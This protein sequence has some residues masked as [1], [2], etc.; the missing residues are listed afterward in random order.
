MFLLFKAFFQL[1]GEFLLVFFSHLA[2]RLKSHGKYVHPCSA[3]QSENYSGFKITVLPVKT[4][5]LTSTAEKQ[6][7]PAE[8]G[9]ILAPL[10]SEDRAVLGSGSPAFQGLH[11]PS[12]AWKGCLGGNQITQEAWLEPLPERSHA[13][14][15]PPYQAGLPAVPAPGAST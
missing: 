4:Q 12:L 7:A 6:P 5:H 2:E 1:A 9:L 15:N 3:L 8:L 11:L 10:H 14:G 13:W